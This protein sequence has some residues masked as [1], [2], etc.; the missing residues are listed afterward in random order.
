MIDRRQIRRLACRD[1]DAEDVLPLARAPIVPVSPHE[2]GPD[3]RFRGIVPVALIDFLIPGGGPLDVARDDE[4]RAIGQPQRIGRAIGEARH[5]PRVAAGDRQH[6]HLRPALARRDEGECLAVGRPA[7]LAIGSRTIRAGPRL[8][9]RHVDNPDARDVTIVL[10]R[11]NRN[12]VRDPFPVGRE[13]RVTYGLESDV[14][15]E[16]DGS[17]LG[18]ER[19]RD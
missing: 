18:D 17:F 2:P 4:R 19:R 1:V 16:G 7:R 3:L 15:V 9:R 11:R 5:L 13:L 6:P 12:G 8:A 14:I 10:E